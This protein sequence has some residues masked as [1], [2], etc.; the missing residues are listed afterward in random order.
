MGNKGY[1][2]SNVFF[3]TNNP[4]TNMD[5]MLVASRAGFTV[6][7]CVMTKMKGKI[8]TTTLVTLIKTKNKLKITNT[9]K[10]PVVMDL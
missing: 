4:R 5:K 6:E 8:N 10:T 3:V 7:K 9:L 2:V 1:P